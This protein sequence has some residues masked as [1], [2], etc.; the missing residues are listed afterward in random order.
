MVIK[1]PNT[2]TPGLNWPTITRQIQDHRPQLLCS[3]V[4]LWKLGATKVYFTLKHFCYLKLAMHFMH[5]KKLTNKKQNFFSEKQKGFRDGLSY[6]TPQKSEETRGNAITQPRHPIPKSFLFFR[7]NFLLLVWLSSGTKLSMFFSWVRAYTIP[8]LGGGARWNRIR[9]SSSMS[10][11]CA[12][13]SGRR[14]LITW[15]REWAWLL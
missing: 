12:S 1:K 6:S 11:S 15:R 2:R 14:E 7:E 4:F 3:K 9:F 10:S 8:Y 13:I 5:S